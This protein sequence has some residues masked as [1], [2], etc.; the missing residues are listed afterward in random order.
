MKSY[1]VY[2]TT[3]N[4][5]DVQLTLSNENKFHRNKRFHKGNI[6]VTQK[7]FTLHV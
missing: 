7:V 3:S 4:C 1:Q 6:T 5:I 2:A